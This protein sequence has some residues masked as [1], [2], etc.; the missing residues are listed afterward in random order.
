MTSTTLSRKYRC[1]QCTNVGKIADRPAKCG[2]RYVK[3]DPLE[4][5]V[6]A[7]VKRLLEDPNVVI[8]EVKHRQSLASPFGEVGLKRVEKEMD[9]LSRQERRLLRLFRFGEINEQYVEEEIRDI[10]RRQAVLVQE[11]QELEKH[12]DLIATLEAAEVD[13]EQ[14][15]A[16]VHEN[17]EG[18]SYDGQRHALDAIDAKVVV[19]PEGSVLYGHLPSY[20]TIARTSGCM[21]KSNQ[22]PETVPFRITAQLNKV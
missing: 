11:K 9:R 14:I 3:A 21:F 19:G 15:C 13:I 2:A 6:L 8:S 12:R 20:V 5:S 17:L 16:S 18:L 7:E 22:K 1:Y 10:R 4:A